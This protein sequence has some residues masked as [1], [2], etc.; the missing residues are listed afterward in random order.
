M[1]KYVLLLF[2]MR[3][4]PASCPICD[5][6]IRIER[7]RC[8]RCGSAIEGDFRLPRLA[9][10]AREDARLAELFLLFD[11]SFKRLAAHLGISY[12]TLR[13]RMTGVIGRLGAL[14]RT[15]SACRRSRARSLAETVDR[16]WRE[17]SEAA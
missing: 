4:S 14:V 10:L 15:D 8:D 1:L 6:E 9:R 13:N 12:P 11:G 3:T 5:G 16:L 17:E 7:A 2:Q